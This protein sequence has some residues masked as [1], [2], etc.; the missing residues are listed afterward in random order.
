MTKEQKQLIIVGILVIILV[1][2]GY[3]GFSSRGKGG[4][5][6]APKAAAEPPAAAAPA[7]VNLPDEGKLLAQRAGNNG[8]W[9]RDPF[10]APGDSQDERIDTLTLQG[11]TLGNGTGFAFINNLIVRKGDR[12]GNYQ[13]ADVFKDKVL[14][15]RGDQKFYLNFPEST[16]EKRRP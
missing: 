14:L 11:I 12:L 13:V 8:Q 4:R 5:K 3:S 16:I 15:Q 2:V 10:G 7:A 6:V 1:A 9:G